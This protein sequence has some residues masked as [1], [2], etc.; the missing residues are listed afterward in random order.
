MICSKFRFAFFFLR[1]RFARKRRRRPSKDSRTA[2]VSGRWDEG[3]RYLYLP[4]TF[5]PCFLLFSF[6]YGRGRVGRGTKTTEVDEAGY[7]TGICIECLFFPV[8]A[9]FEI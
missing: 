8:L 1:F 3:T 6:R 5:C 9:F 4:P 2:A 7:L